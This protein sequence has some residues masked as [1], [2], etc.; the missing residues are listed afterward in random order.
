MTNLVNSQV[1]QV[2]KVGKYFLYLS[3]DRVF[4]FLV[5]DWCMNCHN[6]IKKKFRFFLVRV[7]PYGLKAQFFFNR[8]MTIHIPIESPD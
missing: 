2:E 3:K 1:Y 4:I 7:P 8:V 5:F 6:S